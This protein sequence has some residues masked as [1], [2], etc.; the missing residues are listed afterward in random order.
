M[1]L[2]SNIKKLINLHV[3]TKI[4]FAKKVRK[5]PTKF[6]RLRVYV[7]QIDLNTLVRLVPY[8]MEPS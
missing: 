3:Y 5:N 8:Q 7:P 6:S 4:P 1:T 2:D